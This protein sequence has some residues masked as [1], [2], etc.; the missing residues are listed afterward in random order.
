MVV[1]SYAG[2]PVSFQGVRLLLDARVYRSISGRWRDLYAR[3]KKDLI[4]SVLKSI[5]GLQGRKLADWHASSQRARDAL[6]RISGAE[7]RDS[8]AGGEDAAA[9]G[10]GAPAPRALAPPTHARPA[11]VPLPPRRRGIWKRVF[12]RAGRRSQPS[13]PRAASPDLAHE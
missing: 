5:T 13:S 9:A 11:G 10:N 2:S 1:V 3:L 8:A 4:W 6:A 7:D 12:G